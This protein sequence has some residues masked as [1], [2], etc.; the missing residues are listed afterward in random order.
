MGSAG[1]ALQ[2]TCVGNAGGGTRTPTLFRA[3]GPKPGPSTSSGTPAGVTDSRFGA[4]GITDVPHQA[5]CQNPRPPSGFIS[6]ARC[7]DSKE[8]RMTWE[9]LAEGDAAA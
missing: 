2:T 8:V 7:V 3:P 4:V 6:C 1:C 5:L 9:I